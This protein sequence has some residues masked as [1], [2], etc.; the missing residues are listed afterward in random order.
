MPST[1]TKKIPIQK[2]K[3]LPDFE[4]QTMLSNCYCH[5][6]DEAVEQIAKAISCDDDTAFQLARVAEQ[7]GSVTVYKG[8]RTK[9]ESVA[10]T[11][12]STG[13]DVQVIQ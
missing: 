8:S 9:C 12:G 1:S 4:W 7:F 3:S 6:L 2:T 5:S 13:L 11:L 10:N